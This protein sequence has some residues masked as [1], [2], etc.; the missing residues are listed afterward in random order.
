MAKFDYSAV[1]ECM[2]AHYE[3]WVNRPY[4]SKA[5]S[6]VA[7]FVEPVYDARRGVFDD[8]LGVLK[9]A[10]MPC[11]GF[12]LCSESLHSEGLFQVSDWK[13]RDDIRR[14]HLQT[15]RRQIAQAFAPRRIL[16][17]VFWNPMRSGADLN[18]TLP[19]VGSEEIARTTPTASF[20]KY[21]HLDVDVHAYSAASD[22]VGLIERT[23]SRTT[24]V[25]H[26]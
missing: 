23:P 1:N 14:H 20:A 15:V 25:T 16:H 11:C 19:N 6:S 12:Q 22:F 18:R 10:T 24:Q 7:T 5:R 21:P 4:F 13:N 3:E 17:M 2:V 26:S 8:G 9:P